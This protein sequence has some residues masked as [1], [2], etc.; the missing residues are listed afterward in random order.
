M[1]NEMANKVMALLKPNLSDFRTEILSKI[2][3][4]TIFSD[5]IIRPF[6]H[7]VIMIASIGTVSNSNNAY[8]FSTVMFIILT[9]GSFLFYQDRSSQPGV[10]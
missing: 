7:D 9:K 10:F 8:G 3:L 4:L 6:L 2:V 1:I 5:K